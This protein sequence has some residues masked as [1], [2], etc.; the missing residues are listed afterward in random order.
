MAVPA[1][2]PDAARFDTA[3]IDAGLRA[4]MFTQYMPSE[5]YPIH[6]GF[7]AAVAKDLAAMQGA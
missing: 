2:V 1:P 6:G 5:A 3:R 7:P 4:A